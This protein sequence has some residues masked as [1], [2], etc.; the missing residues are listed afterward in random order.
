MFRMRLI[1]EMARGWE[2][3]S[4]RLAMERRENDMTGVLEQGLDTSKR[5]RFN[6]YAFAAALNNLRVFCLVV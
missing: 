6:R 3:G 2:R 4:T 1:V 5:L